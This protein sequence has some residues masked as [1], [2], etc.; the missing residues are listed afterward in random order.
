MNHLQSRAVDTSN[1]HKMLLAVYS[2]SLNA[3]ILNM[4]IHL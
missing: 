4:R 2:N 3:V 1:L